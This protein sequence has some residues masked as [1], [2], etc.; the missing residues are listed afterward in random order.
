MPI[1]YGS[2]VRQ[3]LDSGLGTQAGGIALSWPSAD[4]RSL[5][6]DDMKPRAMPGMSLPRFRRHAEAGET[7]GQ[8]ASPPLS[9]QTPE[10]EMA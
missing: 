2:P 5:G 8:T 9:G 6:L 3:P 1:R 10:P 7:S 4:I